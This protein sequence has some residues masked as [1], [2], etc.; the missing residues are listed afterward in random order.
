MEDRQNR[1]Q[2]FAFIIGA[3]VATCLCFGFAV[4]GSGRCKL[5]R[6]IKLESRIN[7]NDAPLTSLIRLPGIGT[8]RAETIATYRKNFSEKNGNRPAFKNI[9]DLQKVKGIGPKIA[10]NISKWLKFE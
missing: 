6:Q 2:S 4:S 7:P 1:I 3:C 9:N 8:G 5:P 10:K